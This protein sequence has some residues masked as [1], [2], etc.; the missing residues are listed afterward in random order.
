MRDNEVLKR[1]YVKHS[2][3]HF[4]LRTKPHLCEN[5]L[6]YPVLMRYDRFYANHRLLTLRTVNCHA[7]VPE[8]GL[9]I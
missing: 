7:R 3:T 2:E 8:L 4:F 6:R 1:K 5:E 9:Q